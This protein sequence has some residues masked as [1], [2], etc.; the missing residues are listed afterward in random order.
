MLFLYIAGAKYVSFDNQMLNL[1]AFV[2]SLIKSFAISHLNAR[3]N[4]R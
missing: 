2:R 4:I 3:E 1:E